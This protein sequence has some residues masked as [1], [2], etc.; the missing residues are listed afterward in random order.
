MGQFRGE[1]RQLIPWE[2]LETEESGSIWLSEDHDARHISRP[3]QNYAG[4]RG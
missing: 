1:R 2:R 3:F 4:L